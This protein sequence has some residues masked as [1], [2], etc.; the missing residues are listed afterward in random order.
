MSA[1]LARDAVGLGLRPPLYAA[2][3]APCVGVDYCEAISENFLGPAAPPR[4]QLDA[5]RA[6][7][8]VV[9]HGVGLNLLGH[10]PLDER[11][12]DA[13]CA[14][15]E[16]VDAPFVSDHLCWSASHAHRHHDLLPTP[17]TPALVELAAARA[18]YVQS[19]LG[20][21]FAV[22]NL[23]SYVA[24]DA[25]TM[26]EHEFYA[27]VV[28][29]SGCHALLDLNNVYVSSRNHGFDARAY[30]DA[31]D[32]ARVLEVHLAGHVVLADG[33][34]LDTHDQPVCDAVWSLYAYAWQRGGPFPTML[35]RDDA[36]PAIE[37]LIDELARA[38]GERDRA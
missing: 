37:V 20:R 2:L 12:L 1:A 31:I 30:L 5:V 7:R 14:L 11:Y 38:R 13:L 9:L 27:A 3:R 4:W 8:P 18:A 21:P 33:L 22:E 15:A 34:R 23:S 32:F 6:Q 29:R 17:Y 28:A 35:E 19:R 26:P 10:E 24:F 25:S 36:I 16:A